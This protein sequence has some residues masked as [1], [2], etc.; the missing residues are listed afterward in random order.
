MTYYKFDKY[1]GIV[2]E[3]GKQVMQLVGG[4]A[5]FRGLCGTLLAERLNV[6]ARGDDYAK[7]KKLV[8]D[9]KLPGLDANKPSAC[10]TCDKPHR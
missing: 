2:D 10:P 3:T 6:K 4:T 1:S 7:Q 5:K 9:C 8:C